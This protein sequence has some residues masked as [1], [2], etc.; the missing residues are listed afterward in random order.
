M[1]D[2]DSA[3]EAAFEGIGKTNAVER[4]SPSLNAKLG[5]KH[6]HVLWKIDTEVLING[7]I[8]DFSLF[9]GLKAD[10]PLSLPHIYLSQENFE[11]IKYIP[12]VD[13]DRKICLYDQENIKI[14]PKRPL[15]ILKACLNRAVKV[16]E[17]GVNKSN[18]GDFNEEVVAYWANSY[19]D[20]DRVIGAYVGK[21]VDA[22]AP[23]NIIIYHLNPAYNKINLIWGASEEESDKMLDFFRRRGH[24]IKETAGFYLGE[25]S[26]LKPPFYFTNKS[27]TDFV[28]A[29]FSAIWH[30]VKRYLNRNFETKTFVFSITVN[31]QLVHFGFYFYGFKTEINGWRAASLSTVQ[32]LTTLQAQQPVDRLTF[33]A[34]S[35]DRLKKRTDGILPTK[36]PYKFMIAGLGSIG[37]NLV[38]YLN[39]LEVSDFKLVDPEKLQL[40][41]VNRHLLSFNDVGQAKVEGIMKYLLGQ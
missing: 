6:N 5:F 38:P 1:I 22:V 11:E 31:E 28:K 20:K 9:V 29:Q 12:H 25:I 10:F 36:K 41:N 19:H 33:K 40:E 35:P 17:D 32:I 24:R 23:G 30:D 15:D 26:E 8:R 13:D 14:D 3:K 37:S 27:F 18:E 4:I 21:G 16:I 7:S 34:F 39:A 2:F